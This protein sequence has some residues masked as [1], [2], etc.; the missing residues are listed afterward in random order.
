M[1]A[2]TPLVL[3]ASLSLSPAALAQPRRTVKGVEL[4]TYE[5]KESGDT[6]EYALFVPATY[7]RARPAPLI[8]GLHGLGGR[9]M[10]FMRFEGLTA[11]AESRGYL[12]VAPMGFNPS[13]GYG[14]LGTGRGF[15]LF[16]GAGM[17]E[18]E[19]LGELSELDVMHVLAIVR[20]SY[21]VDARRI[22]LFG[23]S[24]GGGGAWHLGIKYPD[25]WAALA[26]VSPAI[27]TPPD[28]LESI[29]HTPVI[30]IQGDQDRLVNVN[31][32]RRWVEKMKELGMTYRYIE[33]PGGD[34]SGVIERSPEN[35]RSIFDFFE[36]AR[37][38]PGLGLPAS[39]ET[40]VPR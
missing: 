1:R 31:M 38:A 10:S 13:G 11:L 22:Y 28:A 23:H 16:R 37:R 19:N 21:N 27:Y 6:L 35:I 30:V 8:V 36:K 25:L 32:T 17:K 26:P 4:K 14:S 5:F 9:P 29:T 2:L 39:G 33:V 15:A 40:R 7:N 24:M 3:L 20:E 34:H 12:V 18:P